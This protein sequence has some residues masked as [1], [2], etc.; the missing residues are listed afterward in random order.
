MPL[1]VNLP[2]ILLAAF[3]ASVS[4]GPATLA[5]AG[6]SMASGRTSG[7]AL[8]SGITTG[9]LMWSIAAALGLG[10]VMLANA[11]VFEMIRY[12]GAAYL[13]FLAYRAARSALSQKDI[14]TRSFTGGKPTLYAK[15]LAL[16]LTNPK[17]ILFFGSLFSLGIPPGTEVAQLAIVIAAVGLQSFLVFHGYALIFSSQAMTA[18][19]LRLRR[20][21]EGAFAI[22]FGAASLKILTAKVQAP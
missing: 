8:A 6:T 4:P 10:A 20:W 13:M 15:G 12:F 5:L 3:V 17:A 11:W 22:G 14:A 9:S 21:F 19:Y 1:E 7:L 16:H 2:L 18:V